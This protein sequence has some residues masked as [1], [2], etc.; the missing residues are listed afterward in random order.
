MSTPVGKIINRITSSVES[1]RLAAVEI[2]R[3]QS[4]ES[5]VGGEATVIKTCNFACT[6]SPQKP[7]V[8][9][10]VSSLNDSCRQP[11]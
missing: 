7:S 2:A 11:R 4:V 3:S 6:C 1:A 5:T 10:G 9:C 8:P